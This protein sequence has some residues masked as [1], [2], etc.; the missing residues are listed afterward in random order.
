[1]FIA[2]LVVVFIESFDLLGIFS[3]LVNVVSPHGSH[4]QAGFTQLLF[5]V[6]V[7]SE[8]GS[9]L[10]LDL[11]AFSRPVSASSVAA[12]SGN[13]SI[14]ILDLAFEMLNLTLFVFSF[15]FEFRALLNEL[16]I[17]RFA[18]ILQSLKLLF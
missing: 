9:L 17:C 11:F 14:T 12:A 2:Q 18:L 15:V 16:L 5:E 4:L 7:L 8:E 13:A 1:V 10:C 3:A 6:G